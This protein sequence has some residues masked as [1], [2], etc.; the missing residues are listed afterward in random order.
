MR[1]SIGNRGEVIYA[2]RRQPG[3]DAACGRT[4]V[5]AGPA[6]DE[7]RDRI[8]VR[9][10]SGDGLA[11]A[12]EGQCRDDSYRELA[13][14]MEADEAVLEQLATDFYVDRI[15]GRGE[16]LRAREVLERRIATARAGLTSNGRSSVLAGLPVD[17]ERL[18]AWWDGAPGDI[19]RAVVSALVD[20]VRVAP[21]DP[22][23]PR[24]FDPERLTVRW[25]V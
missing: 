2:C 5:I 10:S 20:C 21:L 23:K 4:S 25:R 11:R 17:S 7:V 8:L 24:R 15:L 19:R 22:A 16:F 6:D 12:I 18:R 13:A 9:L 1:S 3:I 14:Q